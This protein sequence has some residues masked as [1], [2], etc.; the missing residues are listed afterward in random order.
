M[1]DI[2]N[3]SFEV[4]FGQ[5]VDFGDYGNPT[6][7]FHAGTKE[8]MPLEYLHHKNTNQEVI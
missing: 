2:E 6:N 7:D 5:R 4:V 3:Q 8:V 1:R